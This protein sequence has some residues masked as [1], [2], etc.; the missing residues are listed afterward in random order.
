MLLAIRK[1]LQNSYLVSPFNCNSFT[2]KHFKL[3]K[4]PL[5][6]SAKLLVAKNTL[7][8]KAV[9]GTKWEALGPSMNGMNALL[10]AKDEEIGVNAVKVCRSFQKEN[11]LQYNDFSGAMIEGK[12]YGHSDLEV[13]ETVGSKTEVDAMLLGSLYTPASTLIILLQGFGGDSKEEASQ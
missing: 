3:L 8:E 7:I 5:P 2:V 13:L 6:D 1:H 11:E 9:E 12:L 4:K 10:F